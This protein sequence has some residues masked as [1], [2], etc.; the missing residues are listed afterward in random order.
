VKVISD[1]LGGIVVLPDWFKSRGARLEV[2]V[3][4]LTGKEFGAFYF[5]H[6]NDPVLEV[7]PVGWIRKVMREH[8]P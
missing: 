5:N 4:L 8:I 6:A 7:A 3:G 2:F 1:T